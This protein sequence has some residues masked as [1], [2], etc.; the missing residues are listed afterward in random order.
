ML[1]KED[2]QQIGEVVSVKVKEEL[3]P[4]HEDL[5]GDFRYVIKEIG[6]LDQKIDNLEAKTDKRFDEVIRHVD[7]FAK[8][9]QKFD[10]ELAAHQAR[11]DRLDP[12]PANP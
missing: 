11:L 5:K 6:R 3:K 10:G 9:Q 4:F 8:V 1:T 12:S 7:G 2:L